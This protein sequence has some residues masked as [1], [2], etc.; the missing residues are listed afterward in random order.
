MQ[1]NI[2]ADQAFSLELRCDAASATRQSA[3][4]IQ[5]LEPRRCTCSVIAKDGS[6]RKMLMSTAFHE[7][8]PTPLHCQLPLA[9]VQ[10][11]TW[12][13][14]LLDMAGLTRACFKG[15][16]FQAV[17]LV[18]LSSAF[19]VFFYET[20]AAACPWAGTHPLC[21]PSSWP[22]DQVLLQVR[23]IFTLRD[24]PAGA[25]AGEVGCCSF[26]SASSTHQA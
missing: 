13:N 1:I 21:R 23:R 7:A 2:G 5:Q 10:Q 18:C 4:M 20:V 24:A 26:W 17:D 12:Q 11:G 16:T 9:G 3:Y 19:K 8:K 15:S 6:R 14:L 22:S 25:R